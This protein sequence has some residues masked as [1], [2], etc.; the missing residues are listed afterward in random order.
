MET[1]FKSKIY[2]ENIYNFLVSI[3]LVDLENQTD[4]RDGVCI[5]PS[6]THADNSIRS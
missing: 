4:V 3:H 5:D 6:E 1:T 2:Y